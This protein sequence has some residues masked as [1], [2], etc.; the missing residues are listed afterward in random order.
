ML[1][2]NKLYIFLL[3]IIF[4]LALG[5]RINNMANYHTAWA[6]DGGGHVVYL[7]KILQGR[8][9]TH[10][11]IYLAWHEPLY[12][13]ALAGW[14]KFWQLLQL[15]YQI[16][17]VHSFLHSCCPLD[18]PCIFTPILN[19]SRSSYMRGFVLPIIMSTIGNN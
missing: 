16:L 3:A 2:N 17:L 9:P 5:I 15:L 1:K 11:E 19:G 18:S 4:V 14:V 8:L 7:E 10:D 13:F 6:D 12:Y